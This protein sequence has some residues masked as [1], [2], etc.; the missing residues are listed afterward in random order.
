MTRQGI[1]YLAESETAAEALQDAAT[2]KLEA[3]CLA[4]EHLAKLTSPRSS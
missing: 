3:S 2:A 4:S 1:A